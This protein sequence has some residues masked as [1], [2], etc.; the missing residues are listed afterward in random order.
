MEQ[1]H[2]KYTGAVIT[3]WSV[4]GDGSQPPLYG[5]FDCFGHESTLTDCTESQY[6]YPNTYC[7]RTSFIGLVCYSG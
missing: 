5:S 3:T 6:T 2:L 7:S 1:Y 4:Y